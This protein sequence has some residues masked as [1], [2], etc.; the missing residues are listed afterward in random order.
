M[1]SGS[2]TKT[3]YV[4][5][6]DI[7]TGHGQERY[8]IKQI[9]HPSYPTDKSYDIALIQLDSYFKRETYQ[10]RYRVNSICLPEKQVMRNDL[11]VPVF[12]FGY[13]VENGHEPEQMNRADLTLKP[14]KYCQKD[15]ICSHYLDT[16]P[17]LCSV[18]Y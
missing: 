15:M 9:R 7:N 1:F 10:G 6:G 14:S 2:F 8:S 11:E 5:A 3:L 18:K 17:R 12:V 13:G 4:Y 16:D